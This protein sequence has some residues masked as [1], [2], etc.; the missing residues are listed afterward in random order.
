MPL[1]V[2][3]ANPERAIISKHKALSVE[4]NSLAARTVTTKA[5]PGIL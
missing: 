3:V 5:V 2:L 4:R 1:T